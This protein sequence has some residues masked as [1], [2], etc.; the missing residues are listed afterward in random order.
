KIVI[1][2]YWREHNFTVLAGKRNF[3]AKIVI[4][5]YW[6]KTQFYSFGEKT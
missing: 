1:L 4:L 3:R 6:R 2:L 5:L